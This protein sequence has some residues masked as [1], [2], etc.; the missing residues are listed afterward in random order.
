MTRVSPFAAALTSALILAPIAG[1]QDVET[2]PPPTTRQP[3]ADV[4]P[5]PRPDVADQP[6]WAGTFTDWSVLVDLHPTQ[7]GFDGTISF[8]GTPY[9]ARGQV[10]DDATTT[11][12]GMFGS[13]G[14]E[15][16]FTATMDGV[17]TML[18]HCAGVNYR[19][20]RVGSVAE[21]RPE[22][23]TS[24]LASVRPGQTWVYLMDGG[25]EQ[26]WIVHDV[27]ADHVS[28]DIQAWVDRGFGFQPDG[29][30]VPAELPFVPLSLARDMAREQ[31]VVSGVPI[32]CVVFEAGDTTS[33]IAVS[34]DRTTFPGCVRSTKGGAVIM[35]LVR[36]EEP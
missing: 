22:G 2:P 18:F 34:G 33:W 6:V 23:G 4:P 11:L 36:I 30:P 9:R 26:R 14:R 28:Y 25:T 31:V 27:A 7:Q 3:G 16:E 35:E 29:Q 20:E 17:D 5:P 12:V 10:R 19:L 1:A 21:P 13:G 15:S 32:E 8:A 24:G